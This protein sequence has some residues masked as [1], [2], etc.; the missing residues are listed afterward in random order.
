MQGLGCSP[1]SATDLKHALMQ[2]IYS[3]FLNIFLSSPSEFAC[4]NFQEPGKGTKCVPVSSTRRASNSE[5]GSPA[6]AA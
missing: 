2:A 5:S 3:P 1:N 6:E 4:E